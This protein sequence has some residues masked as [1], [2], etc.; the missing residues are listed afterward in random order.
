M[1]CL[2]EISANIVEF[3]Y[4][5]YAVRYIHDRATLFFVSNSIDLIHKSA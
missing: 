3:S 5:N 1:E 2:E 4:G